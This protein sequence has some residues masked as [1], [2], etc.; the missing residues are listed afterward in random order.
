MAINFNKPKKLFLLDQDGTLYKGN[1]L[2]EYTL[3][4]LSKIKATGAS[5]LFI[6]N[7]S[8]KSVEVYLQKMANFGII[9]TKKEFYT[10]G[11]ATIDYINTQY[12]DYPVFL[13]GTAALTKEF[14]DNGIN[15]TSD[16][17]KAKVAVLSYD[18]EINYEKITKLSVLLRDKNVVYLAT[19]PDLVCPTED[20]YLPDCGSFAEMI[21]K[22]V[23]R[24]PLYLG[25]PNT[26]FID[27]IV[28]RFNVK[29]EDL[30]IVGDRI[31]TD[32]AL[33]VNSDVESILV[34]S[35]EA[36]LDDVVNSVLKPTY[37]VKN[38]SEII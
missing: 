2:F 16:I 31:Y 29:K 33:G 17:T 22:A 14:I 23:G 11:N 9:A 21:E 6:T 12:H 38:V 27:T 13:V 26:L 19:N 7:N 37:I 5:Y 25:K 3:E 28:N 24:T 4:F 15:L 36:T 8:S 34:L 30:V 1:K 10:S 35:G 32:I 18:T 20:G